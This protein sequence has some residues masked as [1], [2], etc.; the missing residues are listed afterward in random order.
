M[1]IPVDEAKDVY[2]LLGIL[3]SLRHIIHYMNSVDQ[4]RRSHQDEKIKDGG[5]QGQKGKE[6]EAR[7][8]VKELVQVMWYLSATDVDVDNSYVTFVRYI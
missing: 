2:L 1:V 7:V 8:G 3:L 5:G 6:V 4:Q